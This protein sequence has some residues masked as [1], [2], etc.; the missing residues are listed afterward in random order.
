MSKPSDIVGTII[1]VVMVV[2]ALANWGSHRGLE[3]AVCQQPV[4]V[5][6]QLVSCSGK[7]PDPQ[8]TLP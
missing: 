8:R 1:I 5:H 2:L 6:G 3:R 4:S 7:M